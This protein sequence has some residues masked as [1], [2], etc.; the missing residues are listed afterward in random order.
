MTRFQLSL[1]FCYEYNTLYVVHFLMSQTGTNIESTFSVLFNELSPLK[2]QCLS[3]F[4]DLLLLLLLFNLITCVRTESGFSLSLSLSLPVF[5]ILFH[6]HAL[7]LPEAADLQAAGW[8]LQCLRRAGFLRQYVVS[9][10][11][12]S[13]SSLHSS[14]VR[15]VAAF[16]SFKW[17]RGDRPKQFCS[18][19]FLVILFS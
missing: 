1:C 19:F 9:R 16:F 10:H 15:S 5:L 13:S 18:F 4:L 17:D 11:R 8:I 14:Y 6:F 2:W 3:K 7:R 12:C